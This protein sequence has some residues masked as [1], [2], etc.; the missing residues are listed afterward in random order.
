MGKIL[1]KEKLKINENFR[2]TL[3]RLSKHRYKALEE[4]ILS[5]GCQI[6]IE[7]QEGTIIDGH[8]RYEIC[9]R[10]K[11]PFKIRKI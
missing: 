1:L 5:N 9:M 7:V 4:D 2:A 10:H 3:P 8:H 6:P 11:V